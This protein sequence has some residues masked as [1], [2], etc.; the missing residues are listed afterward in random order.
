MEQAISY[1]QGIVIAFS[2]QDKSCQS[3]IT[4]IAIEV[5]SAFA[6]VSGYSEVIQPDYVKGVK[7]F[8]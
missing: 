5:I 6:I 7:E 3:I 4:V 2:L 1:Y 8:H